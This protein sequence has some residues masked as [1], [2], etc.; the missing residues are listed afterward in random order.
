MSSLYPPFQAKLDELLK[1][2]A[3][4]GATYKQTA[5][6]R[7]YEEQNKIYAQGRTAPGKRVSNARGGQSPHN[8]GIAADFVAHVKGKVSWSV[9]DYAVLKEEAEK[10]GLESGGAWKL[11]DWPHVQLPVQA[12]GFT[13]DILD[14]FYK[15]DGLQGVYEKLDKLKW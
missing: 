14:T 6:L 13:W 10:L 15:Q 7:T 5:G 9:K 12:R 3:V 1:N 2:C 11:Q 4:R 8:F